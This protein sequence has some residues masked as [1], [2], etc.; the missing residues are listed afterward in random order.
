VLTQHGSVFLNMAHRL[1]LYNIN[2]SCRRSAGVLATAAIFLFVK[3]CTNSSDSSNR[4]FFGAVVTFELL[5]STKVAQHHIL[6][7][8]NAEK[9]D[10]CNVKYAIWNNF[11]R[12]KRVFRLGAGLRKVLVL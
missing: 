3:S 5:I 4:Y 11:V 7:E 9:M 6:I 10:D 1:P 8:Y 2:Q 12:V